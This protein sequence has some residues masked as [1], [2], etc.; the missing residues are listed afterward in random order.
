VRGPSIAG[1]FIGKSPLKTSAKPG[2]SWGWVSAIDSN[3]RTIWIAGAHRD[4]GKRFVVRVDDKPTAFLEL[5]SAMRQGGASRCKQ[6]KTGL[7]QK[8]QVALVQSKP[9]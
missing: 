5:E 9:A 7:C 6:G 3:E 8:H 1:V 2:W 4:N